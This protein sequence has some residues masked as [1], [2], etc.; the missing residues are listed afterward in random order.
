M[1]W[2]SDRATLGYL[3]SQQVP[4]TDPRVIDAKRRMR[5]GLLAEHIARVVNEAPPLTQEQR[6]RLAVLL[7]SDTATTTGTVA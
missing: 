7:R 1:P 6:D 3:A 5:E 2:K 4:G